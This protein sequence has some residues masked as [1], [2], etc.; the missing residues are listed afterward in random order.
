MA[1][2]SV[3]FLKKHQKQLLKL[4]LPAGLL[5]LGLLVGFLGSS[6][7]SAK[8]QPSNLVW[9]A[10]STVKLPSGLKPFLLKQA[11]CKSYIGSGTAKGVGL[12]AV[13]QVEK[14]QFAKIAYGCSSMLN[15]YIM[16]IKQ[17]GKW[18]LIPLNE[19]FAT[20]DASTRPGSSGL[21]KCSQLAKYK[22][23]KA[24]ESFC[25]NDANQPQPNAIP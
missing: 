13:Y 2:K 1:K 12:W 18:Q 19:Y 16:A 25:I 22:I 20:S 4:R 23:S 10:D 15:S 24:I 6:W 7:L 9:A 21:P 5:T 11:D 17:S 14:D 8:N 3:P